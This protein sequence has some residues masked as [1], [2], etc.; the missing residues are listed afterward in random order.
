MTNEYGNERLHKVLLSALKDIDKICRENDLRYYLHAGTLLGAVNYNGFIPWDDDADVSMF[1]DDFRVLQDIIDTEYK[2]IYFLETYDN[3]PDY[4]RKLNK[5]QI[6]GADIQYED[7]SISP[8]FVDISVFHAIPDQKIFRSIQKFKLEFWDKVL[9]VKSGAIIPT[10]IWSK[11]VL[12][13]MAKIKKDTIG[14]H[15]DNIMQK[16]DKKETECYALMIHFLDNPYTGVNGYINDSV[17]RDICEN[18]KY[19]P[20]E[21]TEFMVYSNPEIDLIRRYG[22]DYCQPYP[23]EKRISKHGLISYNISDEVDKRLKLGVQK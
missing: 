4:F 17:P 14:K 6:I 12:K 8:I 13:G 23:E 15:L 21:D 11:I 16:Y 22:K 1:P 10:S 2:G 18:P 3:T 5:L 7:G 9:S 19:I 20:F